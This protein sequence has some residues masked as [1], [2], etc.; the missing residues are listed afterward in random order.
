ME[1]VETRSDDEREKSKEIKKTKYH[2]E[3]RVVS[4][5]MDLKGEG[6]RG[7]SARDGGYKE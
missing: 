2:G 4:E 5:W 6:S 3:M 7:K 1:K